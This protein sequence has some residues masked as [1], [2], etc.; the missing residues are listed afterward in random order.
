MFYY[1][2]HI[3]DFIR[4]TSR[5]NDAQC[6][7]YLRLIWAYYDTEHPLDTTPEKLAF[8]VGADVEDV[9]QILE[10]YFLLEDGKYIHLRCEKEIQN[11]R[12]KS[13]KASESAN[14]R[15]KNAKGMRTHSERSANETKSDANQEPTTI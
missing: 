9:R 3:G 4:D 8:Q 14:A 10:H 1:S 6:M 15:W 11:F 2:H 7:A 13:K 5:L 12:N